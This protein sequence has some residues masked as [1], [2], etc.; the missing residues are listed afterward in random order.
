[1]SGGEIN[2]IIIS[3]INRINLRYC[4]KKDASIKPNIYNMNI[5]KVN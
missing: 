3:N 2:P 5:T 1:M 4:N